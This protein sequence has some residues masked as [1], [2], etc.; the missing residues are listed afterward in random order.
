MPPP[1]P[2]GA[3]GDAKTMTVNGQTILVDAK[4]GLA[5]YTFNGDGPNQSNCTGGCLAIW[6]VHAATASEK[7]SGNFT[8]FTRPGGSLQWAYKTKPLYTFASDTVANNA[9]GNG[10]QGFSLA[11]P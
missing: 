1:N 8:I 11:T 4:S 3:A 9:T 10:F 7:A 6:P 5:L 2:T